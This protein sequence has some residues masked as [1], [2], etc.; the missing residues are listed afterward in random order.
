MTDKISDEDLRT[1]IKRRPATECVACNS[2]YKRP[3][4]IK[5]LIDPDDTWFYKINICENCLRVMVLH[6]ADLMGLY[7]KN[8]NNLMIS[9]IGSPVTDGVTL[10]EEMK[11]QAIKT[12]HY[13]NDEEKM[14]IA[15]RYIFFDEVYKD[16]K[17][18]MEKLGISESYSETETRH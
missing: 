1:L 6:R 11:E 7:Y 13:T 9:P 18:H 3:S 12:N 15:L 14:V 17:E 5:D 8:L 4:G 2:I 16:F 10:T